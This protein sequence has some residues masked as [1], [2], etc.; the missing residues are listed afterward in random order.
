MGLLLKFVMLAVV[1]YAAW[2]TARRWLGALGIGSAATPPPAPTP[3][4]TA[5]SAARAPVVEETRRCP[6]CGAY[7]SISAG[8]CARPDCP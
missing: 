1:A 2:S 8:K 3:P 7:V 6:A 5:A 4:P